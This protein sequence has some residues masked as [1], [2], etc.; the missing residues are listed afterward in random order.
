MKLSSEL[1]IIDLETTGVWI[2]RDRIVEIA[3][4]RLG[5]SGEERI[6]HKRVNPGMP[7]PPHVSRL[8]GIRDEDVQDAPFFSAIAREVGVFLEGADFAGFNLERFDLPLLQKE[9]EHA[10]QSLDWRSRRIYDAQKVFHVNEKRD[11]AAAY[12]FYCGKAHAQAHSALGDVQATCEILRAQVQ[13]YGK[14]S[15]DLDALLAFDYK[16]IQDF[17]GQ[18]RKFRWWNGDLY[19]VFGRYAKKWGLQE[20]AVRDPAYL[21]W[22]LASDF[23]EEVKNLAHDALEG[24]FPAAPGALPAATP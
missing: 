22:I 4:I 2:E 1:V 19:P 14:G 12:Q 10:G 8:I 23:S 24:K 13:R 7:I 16:E 3:M 9:M 18:E 11:L 5:L 21:K 20:I 15:S 6:F 17:Y